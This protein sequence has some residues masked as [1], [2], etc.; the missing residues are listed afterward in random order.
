MVNVQAYIIDDTELKNMIQNSYSI[1]K[2]YELVCF[3]DD[4]DDDY[5]YYFP[6]IQKNGD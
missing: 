4:D 1:N 6:S 2:R 3:D 5:Y